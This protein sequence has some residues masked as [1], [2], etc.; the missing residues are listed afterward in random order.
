MTAEEFKI[1]REKLFPMQKHAAQ[2]LGVSKSSVSL[3]EAGKTRIPNYVGIILDSLEKNPE[4][5]NAI[6]NKSKTVRGTKKGG[7]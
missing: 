5:V 2:A 4:E 6:V 7:G 3:W 1:R